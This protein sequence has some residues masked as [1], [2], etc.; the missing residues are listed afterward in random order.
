M[1][2]EQTRQAILRRYNE[3]MCAMSDAQMA[4][5]IRSRTDLD[6]AVESLVTGANEEGGIDNITVVLARIEPP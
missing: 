2:D 5:V 3:G 6:A 1:T 4:H